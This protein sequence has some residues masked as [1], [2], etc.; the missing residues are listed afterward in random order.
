MSSP[1]QCG[2][3]ENKTNYQN[4]YLGWVCLPCGS[5]AAT[6]S[7]ATT[8]ARLVATVVKQGDAMR[9]AAFTARPA[10]SGV[11]AGS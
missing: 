6:K 4:W 8:L 3:W 7:G 1:R 2:N 5:P 10:G 9:H 11:G